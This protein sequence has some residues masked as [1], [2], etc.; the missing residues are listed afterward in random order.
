M[1]VRS[2]ADLKRPSRYRA[3][4]SSQPIAL[5]MSIISVTSAVMPFGSTCAIAASTMLMSA[6]LVPD[7]A[8]GGVSLALRVERL[9]ARHG[10]PR[11][12]AVLERGEARFHDRHL[13]RLEDFPR[14]GAQRERF[15]HVAFD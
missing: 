4:A 3:S 5:G 9:R 1:R 10:H 2:P 15:P 11:P 8:V 13:D 12:D 14:R 7:P 6:V